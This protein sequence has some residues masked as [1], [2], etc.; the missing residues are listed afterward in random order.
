[1]H[2]IYIT[3]GRIIGIGFRVTRQGISMG[4][5]PEEK[6]S[7]TWSENRGT[8]RRKVSLRIIEQYYGMSHR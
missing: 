6:I 7:R 2:N 1:M 3:L 8:W 5:W 4:N